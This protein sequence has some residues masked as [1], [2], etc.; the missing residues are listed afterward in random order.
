MQ[1][2]AIF[3]GTFNP[4]HMGHISAARACVESLGLNKLLMIPTNIPPH[5]K[6]PEGSPSPVQRLEMT[7]IAAS[8]IPMAEACAIEIERSGPSYTA[9]TAAEIKA[10]YPESCL[11][12]VIGTDMLKTVIAVVAGGLIM[13]TQGAAATGQVFAGFCVM[14][15]HIYP[16]FYGF[17]GGKG[18]LC[19]ETMLLIVSFP[20]GLVSLLIFVGIVWAT[21][22]VSLGSVCGAL[23]APIGVLAACGKLPALLSLFCVI[24]LVAKH[25]SNIR[26]LIEH[27]ESKLSFQKDLSDKF[28][29]EDF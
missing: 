4:P 11:W 26:R 9:D 8:M 24:L 5:K 19:A 13:G 1:R 28:D 7:A 10:L 16:V 3:G 2:I 14:L 27:K 18:V 29:D 25:R 23:I 15:G 12:L 17:R 21:R 6:L 22:Y 20:T